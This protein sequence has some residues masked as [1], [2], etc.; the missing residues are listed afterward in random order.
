VPIRFT[1][2]DRAS[3][4]VAVAKTTES[5]TKP[6]KPPSTVK[7]ALAFAGF[8]AVFGLLLFWPAGRLD[9]GAGWLYLAVLTINMAI[10]YVSLRRWNPELIEHRMRLGKGTETWDK[11]WMGLFAPAFASVY[12][13][14]GLDAGR[15]GWSAMSVWLWPVGL[16]L[17]LTGTVLL[18]WSMVVNPFFEK[19]VRIQTERGHQVIDTGPYRF[20]RHPGYVG[21]FGWLLSA[22][23]LLGSWGA[24]FPSILAIA[25]LVVRTALEDRTLRNGLTGYTEYT[26]RVRFRL[27][28]KVW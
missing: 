19:T 12:V 27:I 2:N 10:N 1:G 22:P 11:I 7:V 8:F 4:I 24:F 20:V 9:W 13:V 15:F 5:D 14:A 25:A 23:L 16:A 26:A 18:T 3:S 28:P 17:F 21:V 6:G